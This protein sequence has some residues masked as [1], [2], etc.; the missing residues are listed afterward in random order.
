MSAAPGAAAQTVGAAAAAA[1]GAAAAT[2][3]RGGASFDSLPDALVVSIL[4]QL[5]QYKARSA[6]HAS[7]TER[8]AANCRL[9]AC[10]TSPA[11]CVPRFPPRSFR[12]TLLVSKRFRRLRLSA[13][14]LST[15][16]F[17]LPGDAD[18]LERA[19]G[20]LTAWLRRHAAGIVARLHLEVRF[21]VMKADWLQEEV[22]EASAA[23]EHLLESLPALNTN[24]QLLDLTI[25][26]SAAVSLLPKEVR[27]QGGG[28]G[29]VAGS[30]LAWREAVGHMALCAGMPGVEAVGHMPLRAGLPGGEA[31]GRWAYATGLPSHAPHVPNPLPHTPCQVACAIPVS[32]MWALGMRSLQKLEYKLT[33][34]S[35]YLMV[36][37]W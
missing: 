13:P 37:L 30:R 1:S 17:D 19:A 3:Q 10:P 22:G 15:L 8:A 36:S 35:G 16:R 26:C 29:R 33:D 12:S 7:Q 4:Q 27:V 11:L 6:K 2:N 25:D 31:V 23:L 34:Y 9:P 28:A 14:L 5:P 24:S 21:P 18:D 20:K 32:G